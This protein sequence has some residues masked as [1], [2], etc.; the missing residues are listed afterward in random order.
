MAKTFH[1]SNVNQSLT[2][3]PSARD[4]MPEGHTTHNLLKLAAA[5]G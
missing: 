2:F 5:T 1:D 4:F 3:P